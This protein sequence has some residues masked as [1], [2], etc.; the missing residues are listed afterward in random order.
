MVQQAVTQRGTMRYQNRAIALTIM[1]VFGAFTFAFVTNEAVH[2]MGHWLAHTAYGAHVGVVLDPFGGAR[3]VG[4][5]TSSA[6]L[7]VTSLAGPLFSLIFST[8]VFIAIWHW[9]SPMSAPF[10]FLLPIAMIQ[11][12][13]TF[14]LGFLT[15]GGDAVHVASWGVSVPVLAVLGVL[16]LGAGIAALGALLPLLG[17]PPAARFGTI[18]VAAGT[19]MV[20]LMLLRFAVSVALRSGDRMEAVVPLVFSV[21]L[22]F[23]VAST[24][25]PM[26]RAMGRMRSLAQPVTRPAV[27]LCM[28]LAATTIALQLIVLN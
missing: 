17:V 11:E 9:R 28:A 15:P 2:E 14:S 5:A 8:L 6:P 21:L 4:G 7:T 26:Q 3:I 1:G 27:S 20:A 16:L 10:L 12:G 22:A 24:F 19:G 18:L 25:R 23:A 13:V